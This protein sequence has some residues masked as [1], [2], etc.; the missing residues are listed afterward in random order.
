MLD[1]SSVQDAL[2]RIQQ[3]FRDSSSAL[4]EGHLEQVSQLN[5][6]WVSLLRQLAKEPLM[7]AQQCEVW[8]MHSKQLTHCGQYN[9]LSH[10]FE[11]A[12]HHYQQASELLESI[13]QTKDYDAYFPT[14]HLRLIQ[15]DCYGYLAGL[16]RKQSR[17]KEAYELNELA[18]DALPTE[19]TKEDV[20][21][22]AYLQAYLEV[23][24]TR[25]L[26][27]TDDKQFEEAAT[28]YEQSLRF[29]RQ[30]DFVVGQV[31]TLNN[32]GVLSYW[33]S[34][35]QDDVAK[36]G[37]YQRAEE[38]FRTV[39]VLNQQLGPTNF[40][41]AI[42][43]DVNLGTLYCGIKRYDQA[44]VNLG[45]A[46]MK[47]DRY[48]DA[49]NGPDQLR[50]REN[51]AFCEQMMVSALVNNRQSR[52]AF[53]FL[54][55][56]R[57]RSL[58]E[59]SSKPKRLL[60]QFQGNEVRNV[61]Q[62]DEAFVT[63]SNTDQDKYVVLV[64]RADQTAALEIIY[65]DYVEELYTKYQIQID[66]LLGT[67][68]R[69][70]QQ[71][72][73]GRNTPTILQKR[74]K[75][76]NLLRLIHWFRLLLERQDLFELS[77]IQKVAYQLHALLV[78]PILPYLAGIS[79]LHI[80]TDGSLGLLPFE[81]LRDA[82]N[83]Y[84]IEKYTISYVRTLHHLAYFMQR[85]KQRKIRHSMLI[86]K[87]SVYVQEQGERVTE[88]T[89]EERRQI[90][91][92]YHRSEL[93]DDDFRKLYGR[94][95]FPD[96]TAVNEEIKGI[97]E[98]IPQAQLLT[99][100]PLTKQ[101][102]IDMTHQG[103]MSGYQ[104]IHMALHG[105][106]YPDLPQLSALLFYH[107]EPT[108]QNALLTIRELEEI[109]IEADFLSL[110]A[111]ETAI[112]GIYQTEGMVGIAQTL[113]KSGVD[114]VLSSLW[115]VDSANASRFMQVY[116]QQLGQSGMYADILRS[117][118]LDYIHASTYRRHP[119]YWSAFVIHGLPVRVPDEII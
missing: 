21:Y 50:L 51:Q 104:Y 108:F 2:T 36:A 103:R 80:S 10:R 24:N 109:D 91:I 33:Q 35:G 62:P 42:T 106:A 79:K 61:L 58:M 75:N 59:L 117:I 49:V 70:T 6:E 115:E 54:E 69:F 78:E 88:L 55:N 76:Y 44:I 32:L 37:Y 107:S 111:C 30:H 19:P 40:L 105:V 1:Q 47:L 60:H 41:N 77:L 7:P 22:S 20:S 27:L 98:A 112:G 64:V 11:E 65:Y 72:P 97:Q 81:V 84:L 57:S 89:E 119:A 8:L 14:S 53:V 45:Q 16:Y 71:I 28:I 74:A 86:V 38:Y 114:S 46:L 23:Y 12:E 73:Y 39:Q 116:Y 66:R 99:D 93:T 67:K 26:L 95:N 25:A 52:D 34:F 94:I 17:R 13:R 100:V 63:F 92:R 18:I 110:A 102:F 68:A 3:L 87:N 5:S 29:A 83:A 43:D 56:R 9:E 82:D 85:N 48:A 90:L 96:L 15:S 31:Q 101:A 4:L 113:L 118:K